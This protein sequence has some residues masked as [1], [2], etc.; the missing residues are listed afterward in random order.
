[1]RQPASSGPCNVAADNGSVLNGPA[2]EFCRWVDDAYTALLQRVGRTTRPRAWSGPT[3]R[4]SNGS[5]LIF[6]AERSRP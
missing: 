2:P 5:R 3:R 4:R 6:V 1:M